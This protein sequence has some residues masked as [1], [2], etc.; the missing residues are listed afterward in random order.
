MIRFFIAFFVSVFVFQLNAKEEI[1]LG[2]EYLKYPEV[3]E[4]GYDNYQR[5]FN[6]KEDYTLKLPDGNSLTLKGSSRAMSNWG[7]L[8]GLSFTVGIFKGAAAAEKGL[9]EFFNKHAFL[10]DFW[11]EKS[12]N[13]FKQ[14]KEGHNSEL[15]F[16]V[17]DLYEIELYCNK[18]GDKWSVHGSVDG[19]RKFTNEKILSLKKKHAV[20]STRK[21]TLKSGVGN[22]RSAYISKDGSII[23]CRD[24]AISIVDTKTEKIV[25]ELPFSGSFRFIRMTHDNSKIAIFGSEKALIY[26]WPEAKLINELKFDKNSSYSLQLNPDFTKAIYKKSGKY[27]LVE[28]P[29]LKVIKDFDYKSDGGYGFCEN[30]AK[31]YFMSR[32]KLDLI[33]LKDGSVIKTFE[34]GHSCT[35]AQDQNHLIIEGMWGKFKVV[36]I[37]TGK[38]VNDLKFKLGYKN[39]KGFNKLQNFL[40]PTFNSGFNSIIIYNKDGSVKSE[41]GPTVEPGTPVFHANGKIFSVEYR[42]DKILVWDLDKIK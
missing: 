2:M 31:A 23:A 25:G 27:S 4:K 9:N 5:G 14:L 22:N 40:S 36:N 17:K 26:S 13:T 16:L 30:G 32:S 38:V 19:K 20:P 28:F 11:K 29:S 6:T 1:T 7:V 39:L 24:K 37:E 8:K 12:S 33:K 21:I 34:H 35:L 3:L 42:S 18:D 15:E 10:K 41:L